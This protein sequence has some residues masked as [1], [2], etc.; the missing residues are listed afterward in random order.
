MTI[1]SIAI[2]GCGNIGTSIAKGL[3]KSGMKTNKIILTRRKVKQLVNLK[4]AGFQVKN[5]NGFAVKNSQI[6]IL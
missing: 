1:S 6:I 3:A 2:L 4:K 5:N